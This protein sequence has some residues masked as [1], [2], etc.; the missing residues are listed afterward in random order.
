MHT[1]GDWLVLREAP[2]QW[3]WDATVAHID[4]IAR[5][6]WLR[7]WR[8]RGAADYVSPMLAVAVYLLHVAG[9]ARHVPD[10][11]GQLWGLWAADFVARLL[12]AE[13]S[14]R[15]AGPRFFSCFMLIHPAY[16]FITSFIPASARD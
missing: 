2:H 8:R 7:A 13:G 9:D 16:R 1:L 6:A 11:H 10:A 15:L 12:L 4:R 5:L 14:L 3:T